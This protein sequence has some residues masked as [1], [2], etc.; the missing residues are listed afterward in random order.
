[1][2][3]IAGINFNTNNKNK[4]KN[5]F[6][7]LLSNQETRG[8]DST[9]FIY[10]FSKD[11]D[12][13]RGFLK[14][15]A[16]INYIK[17]RDNLTGF[18]GHARAATVGDKSNLDNVHP[19]ETEHYVGVHNGTI[20]NHKELKEKY[21][22]KCSGET[23]SEIIF[24]LLDKVGNKA[25]SL[26]EGTFAVVYF[27][28]TSPD[29]MYIFTN[30]SKPLVFFSSK[31]YFAFASTIEEIKIKNKKLFGKIKKIDPCMLYKIHK[32]KLVNKTKLKNKVLKVTEK[33]GEIA[34]RRFIFKNNNVVIHKSYNTP[35]LPAPLDVGTNIKSSKHTYGKDTSR[36]FTINYVKHMNFLFKK[37]VFKKFSLSDST[38]PI[39]SLTDRLLKVNDKEI[40]ELAERTN[41]GYNFYHNNTAYSSSIKTCSWTKSLPFSSH[42]FLNTLALS[43]SV[44]FSSP[45]VKE[46]RAL[47]EVISTLFMGDT[48]ELIS[49]DKEN[50]YDII[51]YTDIYFTELKE[52]IKKELLDTEI[53]KYS[54]SKYIDETRGIT[55]NPLFGT[56]L[57]SDLDISTVF[58]STPKTTEEISAIIED[59]FSTSYTSTKVY[60]FNCG[61]GNTVVALLFGDILVRAIELMQEEK[62]SGSYLDTNALLIA[63]E[64]KEGKFTY[65]N[66]LKSKILDE[67]LNEGFSKNKTLFKSSLTPRNEFRIL[68]EGYIKQLNV[69]KGAI[70][71]EEINN[72]IGDLSHVVANFT[73]LEEE[74]LVELNKNRIKRALNIRNYLTEKKKGV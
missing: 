37:A 4:M 15:S 16:A 67:I 60:N 59:N 52:Y 68:M 23:D 18:L 65:L 43:N 24:R 62:L 54:T 1:M 51:T 42:L 28:K 3:G 29:T 32:G 69:P 26:L 7:I 25:F 48:F 11:Y 53:I 33:E 6:S 47:E 74:D 72:L 10:N 35:R 14:A 5:I 34:Y 50:N 31:E 41:K 17:E 38:I 8:K 9:G 49:P 22:L 73:N 66:K 64:A 56:R 20:F 13:I 70:R 61:F 58:G 55:E 21:K 2:C 36:I 19:I 39:M 45:M 30:G 27:K 40:V 63:T 71:P 12:I 57:F 44:S 46:D